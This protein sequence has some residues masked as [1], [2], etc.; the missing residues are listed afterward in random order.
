VQ[1]LG[2][3]SLAVDGEKVDLSER[4]S[5]KGMMFTGVPNISMVFGYTNASWTLKADLINRHVC[6]LLNHMAAHGYVSATPVP[7]ADGGVAPFVDLTSGYIQR[8]LDRLPKQGSRAPWKVHQNYFLD[9][10][11]MRRAVDDEGISFQ[12]AGERQP[13]PVG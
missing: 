4:V 9:R 7:P 5:Y 13:E 10:L 1:P 2:G 6:R 12:R 3:M 11:M 8:S